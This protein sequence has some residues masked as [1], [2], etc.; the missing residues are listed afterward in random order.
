M[1][2]SR[3]NFF[4]K[5]GRKNNF[6][7]YIHFFF[8]SFFL[9]FLSLSLSGFSSCFR[10]GWEKLGVVEKLDRQTRPPKVI[11]RDSFCQR[12]CTT[13]AIRARACWRETPWRW[14]R[15]KNTT[16]LW[17]GAPRPVSLAVVYIDEEAVAS[18]INA[19]LSTFF[20]PFSPLLT[21]ADRSFSRFFCSLFPPPPHSILS[22]S[23]LISSPLRRVSKFPFLPPILRFQRERFWREWSDMGILLVRRICRKFKFIGWPRK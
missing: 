2:R 14:V 15:S 22:R 16:A 12:A 5:T 10:S 19:P 11:S 9:S 1:C 7:N 17:H 6:K 13:S 8:T 3:K 21:Q 23:N 18:A 20:P 4:S